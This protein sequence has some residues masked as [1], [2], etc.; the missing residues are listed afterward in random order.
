GHL[1]TDYKT[2]RHIKSRV[3][4]RGMLTGNALQ[5]PLYALLT[6]C[7]IEV[8]RV[9]RGVPPDVAPFDGFKS[10]EH[11]CGV[12]ETLRTVA[13]L[14]RVGSFPIRS[15]AHC[16]WCDYASACRPNH[17]PTAFREDH[18]DDIR[19]VRDCW[20]KTVKTPTLKAVRRETP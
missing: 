7:P 3:D 13:E 6:G 15:G 9:S 16:D 20:R 5:V 1:V 19:D 18:A 14:A 2:G 10:A 17:P 8:V 12:V 11:E 4:A